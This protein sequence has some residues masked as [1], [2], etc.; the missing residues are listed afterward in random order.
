[1]K[2]SNCGRIFSYEKFYGICPKCGMYNRRQEDME[3][4]QPKDAVQEEK[5]KDAFQ[6]ENPMY[7]FVED[8]RASE[9]K[10]LEDP[11]ENPPE[12]PQSGSASLLSARY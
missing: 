7:T 3:G 5:P 11:P 9:E 6:G 1:M 2:C 10:T 12:N 4:D 8:G